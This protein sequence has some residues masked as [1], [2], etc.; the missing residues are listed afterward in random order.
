MWKAVV[1]TGASK[2]FGKAIAEAISK[3]FQSP[4][5]FVLHGRDINDLEATRTMLEQQ[6]QPSNFMCK[7]VVA[8]VSKVDSLEAI[9]GQLFDFPN[10]SPDQFEE[11]Y[12]FN[13]AGSLGTLASIGSDVHNIADFS[14]AININVTA[15]C[16]LSHEF[17]RR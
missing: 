1:I 5:Y 9:A 12:F 6:R 3:E 13:N 11:V 17:V 15:S 7:L 8:D 10:D 2:G 14:T 16:F 4:L